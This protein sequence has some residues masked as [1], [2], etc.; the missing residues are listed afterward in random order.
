[1]KQ[2]RRIV[3][4]KI[5][6]IEFIKNV[7]DE[8]LS[9]HVFSVAN[10]S[11]SNYEPI[12]GALLFWQE[13]KDDSMFTKH[14]EYKFFYD[15]GE[16]K[17]YASVK[18][19]K[20]CKLTRD[21]KQE[22]AYILLEQRGAIGSYSFET[23]KNAAN[24]L[25]IH[26][27]YRQL[28]F[29][30]EFD[31]V[32]FKY[33]FQAQYDSELEQF[34]AEHPFYTKQFIKDY[35]KWMELICQA[36]PSHFEKY[37]EKVQM[38]QLC[39]QN[40]YLTEAFIL[41]HLSNIDWSTLQYNL[42]VL[43]RL[44]KSFKKYMLKQLQDEEIL[45]IDLQTSPNKFIEDQSFYHE[46]RV[47]YLPQDEE[48][49]LVN[50][51]F[52]FFSYDRG[53]YIWPGSEHMIKSIPSFASQ[54]YDIYGDRKLTNKEMD[55]LFEVFSVEQQYLFETS[56]ELHWLNR[57]KN[58]MNWTN[59][60]ELN[61]HLNDEFIEKHLKYID[62]EALAK[63]TQII[64]SAQFV[65]K[66]VLKLKKPTITP[67]LLAHLTE[68]LYIKYKHSI[69]LHLVDIKDYEQSLSIEQIELIERLLGEQ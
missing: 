24:V 44:S 37:I 19:P 13:N 64:L 38:T 52:Y 43:D 29:P 10:I 23:N 15:M 35:V 21:Q 59:I 7:F 41:R 4:L 18:F 20:Y 8:S 69:P 2:C 22:L 66:H 67:L 51:P 33:V 17:Y 45:Q 12:Y 47:I 9:H 14:G 53:R 25:Q 30:D 39:Y 26:R 65:E 56:C 63:N 42:P 40:E 31:S 3:M 68:E 58:Q 34:Q 1:M 60:C 5:S 27:L 32:H 46:E 48:D 62:F 11:F 57:Y 16:T 28:S 61:P 36:H 49:Q 54:L 55:R 50:G 6:K